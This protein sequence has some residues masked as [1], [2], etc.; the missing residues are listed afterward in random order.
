[1]K[2][3]STSLFILLCFYSY[4]YASGSDTNFSEGKTAFEAQK[5]DEA[6]N[7]FDKAIANDPNNAEAYAYRGRA[8]RDIDL[9]SSI[10]DCTKAIDLNPSLCQ[11][12]YGRG[13][14][15]SISKKFDEAIKDFN[16]AIELNPKFAEAYASRGI[17]KY[18]A[19]DK[20]GA[21]EDLKKAGELGFNKA[22]EMI[23]RFEE[24]N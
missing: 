22:Y 18:Y 15:E 4:G 2:K 13:N 10:D 1:M 12:Y 24:S 3:L 9:K 16:K 11:A 8:K 7:Y 19:G 21:I 17:T 20:A 23:R 6:I 5:Y 14:A